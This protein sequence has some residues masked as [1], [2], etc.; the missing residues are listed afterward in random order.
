[1]VERRTLS[2]WAYVLA[3]WLGAVGLMIAV[4][5][6]FG[7]LG[8]GDVGTARVLIPTVGIAVAVTWAFVMAVFA[9]R[10]LDEFYVEASKF[11][12]YWGGAAGLAVSVVAYAFIA[13]G[14]LHWLDPVHFHLGRDLFRGFQTG[15]IVGTAFPVLGFLVAHVWWRM[16]KR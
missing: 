15:Y 9:F 12:W 6:I 16:A 4:R 10:K 3:G 7:P 13:L 14:G 5:L 2:V 8:A 1:M 11:A